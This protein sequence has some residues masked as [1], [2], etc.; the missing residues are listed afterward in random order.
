MFC[1]VLVYSS[2][3]LT[4][5]LLTIRNGEGGNT[6]GKLII[7]TRKHALEVMIIPHRNFHQISMRER[8]KAQVVVGFD[9]MPTLK[10][11]NGRQSLKNTHHRSKRKAVRLPIYHWPNGIVPYSYHPSIEYANRRIPHVIRAAMNHWEKHTCIKFEEQRYNM[12]RIRDRLIVKRGEWCSSHLG[13]VGGD[14][15]LYVHRECL[16]VG[17]I[18]HE[19]G[20][21]IGWIHEQARPDR[22]RHIRVI[23]DRIPR[24]YRDQYQKEPWKFVDTKDLPYDY[25]SIMH[26]P[27]ND[28]ELITVDRRAQHR[29][30]QREKL[31]FYD[32]KL[33]NIMYNCNE[34]CSPEIKCKS[35]GFVNF[36]CA[37]ICPREE[38]NDCQLG[39]PT[40]AP[41][42][43]MKPLP[44]TIPTIDGMND[45][46]E[47]TNEPLYNTCAWR[48]FRGK[49]KSFQSQRM[50]V[51]GSIDACKL[52]CL[53]E[54]EFNC[55]SFHFSPYIG[56]CYLNKYWEQA[57]EFEP[58]GYFYFEKPQCLMNVDMCGWQKV[59][60]SYV[61]MDDETSNVSYDTTLN[62]CKLVCLEEQQFRC[63]SIMFRKFR[64]DGGTICVHTQANRATHE[65]KHDS[66]ID[67]YEIMQCNTN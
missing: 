40:P 25:D 27:D 62:Q 5:I 9:I 33:A 48:Y 59:P 16:T 19:L 41:M 14:Q 38:P 24:A 8:N 45:N 11:S 7:G 46:T 63:N 60:M 17:T 51:A 35:P 15:F 34:K 57:R 56:L 3:T 66:R 30:G 26:Y 28:G 44:A 37:C 65:E 29:I 53:E 52:R 50:F 49:A 1:T 39:G 54:R 6:S 47:S 2:L 36:R 64:T 55:K 31:S 21:T 4:V 13:R 10:Q 12:P 43:S 18:I 42:P 20:H 67:Y 32:K 22:D 58:S 23:F 61:A